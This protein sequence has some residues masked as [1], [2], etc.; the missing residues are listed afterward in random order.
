[1]GHSYSNRTIRL[2]LV[3]A[4]PQV[5]EAGKQYVQGV[6]SLNVSR[7][8]KVFLDMDLALDWAKAR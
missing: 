6:N 3:V 2:A 1:M 4:D 5:F 7:D 8:V